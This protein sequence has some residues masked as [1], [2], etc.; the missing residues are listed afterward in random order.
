MIANKSSIYFTGLI[1][2][3]ISIVFW[4]G[5]SS[6]GVMVNWIINVALNAVISVI[7]SLAVANYYFRK[8]TPSERIVDQIRYGLQHAL[9]PTLYPHFFD[10]DRSILVHP[11]QAVPVNTDMPHV[12]LARISP[13]PVTTESNVEILLKVRDFGYNLANP[14]G[15]KV[16]DHQGRVTGVVALGLGF[17]RCIIPIEFAPKS[18]MTITIEL[19]DSGEHSRGVP[20]RNVQTIV[21]PLERKMT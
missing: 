1:Q 2:A 14:E 9:F 3:E 10:Q 5:Y 8:V 17:C 12:E 19:E 13:Y 15:I 20:N 11:E 4:L 18:P 21:I 6:E 7:C 16:R